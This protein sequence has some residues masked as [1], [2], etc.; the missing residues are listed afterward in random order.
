MSIPMTEEEFKLKYKTIPL[1]PLP[2][3]PPA[4]IEYAPVWEI[5]VCPR[6][7]GKTRKAGKDYRTHKTFF[8]CENYRC[9]YAQGWQESKIFPSAIKAIRIIYYTRTRGY[10]KLY[11]NKIGEKRLKVPEQWTELKV[12]TVIRT[13][14]TLYRQGIVTRRQYE[15]KPHITYLSR[16][17]APIS[18][19]KEFHRKKIDAL[20]AKY[21][22][23]V[24]RPNDCEPWRYMS[25]NISDLFIEQFYHNSM[26]QKIKL[27]IPAQT[28]SKTDSWF[29]IS[30]IT[31]I[32]NITSHNERGQPITFPIGTD[33]P[34]SHYAVYSYRKNVKVL[35]EEA[36]EKLSERIEDILRP[37]IKQEVVE[38]INVTLKEISKVY[39]DKI[40]LT[41]MSGRPGYNVKGVI[42]RYFIMPVGGGIIKIYQYTADNQLQLLK[43]IRLGGINMLS[44]Q[45]YLVTVITH[46]L[47]DTRG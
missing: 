26:G 20:F 29:Q 44:L 36:I 25:Y 18:V 21:G 41:A 47:E 22:F 23:Q 43:I 35:I 9:R 5:P 14:Q 28:E 38:Q 24:L 40:Q 42:N 2:G 32:E 19:V 34:V 45:N 4:K 7:G 8:L 12:Q 15:Q 17:Y 37:L 1:P 30:T 16:E 11:W 46:L 39:S 31:S 33:N 13:F 27:R 6:C 3:R 10:Y